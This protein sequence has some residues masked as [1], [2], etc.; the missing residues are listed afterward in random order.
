MTSKRKLFKGL[1]EY[2]SQSEKELEILYYL[3]SGLLVVLGVSAS[4][5]VKLLIDGSHLYAIISG[6]LSIV[7][8]FCFFQIERQFRR[9][10]RSFPL[11]ILDNLSAEDDLKKVQS[12]FRRKVT[13]DKYIDNSI[14]ALNINTC[15]IYYGERDHHL[16]DQGLK[17]GLMSVIND[18]I[19]R[20]NH[21]LDSASSNYTVGVYFEGIA[22]KT[23]T[24]YVGSEVQYS[25]N[26]FIFRDDIELSNKLP[27][28]IHQSN[29]L[30]GITHSLQSQLSRAYNHNKFNS[31][32]IDIKEIGHT[33]IVSPIQ[34]ICEADLPSGLLF[35]V[36]D[37][38]IEIKKDLEN[39]LQIF[40]RIMS[41]WM[42]KYNN[43]VYD[44]FQ[45]MK[46]DTLGITDLISQVECE[47]IQC[48]PVPPEA[49]EHISHSE[50]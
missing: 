31:K 17:E 34:A 35:I 8:F 18:L 50:N 21:V 39:I 15:N 44:Q 19:Y 12:D 6:I 30:T 46:H 16:C 20:I 42:D 25:N 41:N 23:P 45:K 9:R 7:L 13:I 48:C 1:Q 22:Q 38:Q 47:K 33:S 24:Y 37:D 36:V 2:F 5:T 4:A 32:C 10:N 29:Q 28:D 49:I 14:K 11:T 26:F 27:R 3:K 43:C 40:G